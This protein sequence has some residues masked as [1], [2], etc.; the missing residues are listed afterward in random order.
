MAPFDSLH[1]SIYWRS[2][3]TLVLSYIVSE[4]KRDIG[5]KSRFL[6]MH[7]RGLCHLAVSVRPFVCLSVTFVGS[8]E[9]NKKQQNKR[10]DVTAAQRR[11]ATWPIPSC[12]LCPSV[13]FAYCIK[14]NK[15]IIILLIICQPNR[16]CF[17]VPNV[18]TISRL[19]PPNGGVQCRF[20]GY[21]KNRDFRPT[22]RFI[23]ETIQDRDVVTMEY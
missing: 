6:P 3:V 14:T 22:C 18:M 12:A 23:S 11:H 1:T 4:I 8:I 16:S 13:S 19:R 9:T 17:S 10:S 21:E 7:K 5:R 20:M 2:V 15:H